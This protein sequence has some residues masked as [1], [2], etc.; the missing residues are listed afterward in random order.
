MFAREIQ[1]HA[2]ADDIGVDKIF[3]R[4]NASIDMRFGGEIYDRETLMLE[5]E[6][7]DRVGIGN[8]G[9]EKFVALAM[10]F[11]HAFEIGEITG[12]SEGVDICDGRRLV[13]LQDIAN[14]IAPDE[15]AAAGHEN[16]HSKS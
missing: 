12:I 10:F 13:M 5:H 3:R 7:V 2:R 15:A 16:S 14:K 9:F 4:I 11:D 1:K 8:V 6:R